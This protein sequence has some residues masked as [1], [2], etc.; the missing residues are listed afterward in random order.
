MRAWSVSRI[1]YFIA[2]VP[3]LSNNC[4]DPSQ[5]DLAL[6]FC[7]VLWKIEEK[8]LLSTPPPSCRQILF[9]ISLS[10]CVINLRRQLGDTKARTHSLFA[11]LTRVLCS[12]TSD[13][14]R[15]KVEKTNNKLLG[16]GC[17]ICSKQTEF[18][19][20]QKAPNATE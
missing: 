19:G 18:L 13:E 1:A 7:S 4:I 5:K 2:L 15:C 10:P 11:R 6:H 9:F 14:H 8:L 20:E 16:N 3:F 17:K 12:F